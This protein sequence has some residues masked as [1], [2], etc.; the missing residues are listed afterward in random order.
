MRR[1]GMSFV[2]IL[3]SGLV[4]LLVVLSSGGLLSQASGDAWASVHEFHGALLLTEVADQ[5]ASM[6]FGDLPRG[7]MGM[8]LT[9]AAPVRIHPAYATTTLALSPLAPGFVSRS[10]ALSPLEGAGGGL[11]QVRVAAVYRRSSGHD[12]RMEMVTVVGRGG[13][14]GVEGGA[15]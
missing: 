9:A 15:R 7:S 2:E 13:S 14:Y 11:L 6:P 4:L 10:L 12:H 8:D 5:V 3:F 1:A